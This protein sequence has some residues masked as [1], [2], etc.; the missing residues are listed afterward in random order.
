MAG[1]AGEFTVGPAPVLRGSVAGEGTP[2]VLCHGLTASRRYV[3]QGSRALERAGHRVVLYDARGHGESDA[4]PAGQSYGYPE[5]IADLERVV[6]AEVGGER[7]LLGGHSMGAHTAV[8]YALAHPERLSGL[9]V[10]GPTY[11]GE[12]RPE[13]LAYWDGLASALEAGGIE[14]FVGYIVRESSV[15][16]RW[17]DSVARV[18][19]E[20]ME[21]HR[22][23]GAI[24][25]ALRETPASRPFGSLEEL[26]GLDVPALVVASRDEADPGHP[27]EV[28]ELYKNFLPRARLISED[29]GQSPLAWQGGRLSREISLFALEPDVALSC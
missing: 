27:Y 22:D 15:G 10:I 29:E 14:G 23:L 5:L 2:I 16:E 25:R 7:F 1:V 4:A 6:E 28:A 9:V 3:V 26:A 20:R 24:A 12:I 17:R 21:L 13:S 18:S 8:G 11:T 19:A